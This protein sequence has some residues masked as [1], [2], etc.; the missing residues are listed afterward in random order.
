[1]FPPIFVTAALAAAFSW[2]CIDSRSDAN[3]GG[4]LVESSQDLMM[5]AYYL[6]VI[7][8]IGLVTGISMKETGQ[9]S[10]KGATPAAS[11]IREAKENSGRA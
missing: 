8:V 4:P 11:D 3:A 1:M 9:S 7:V 6:M 2:P 10:V 5:P